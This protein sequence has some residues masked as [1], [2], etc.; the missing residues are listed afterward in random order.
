MIKINSSG[1]AGPRIEGWPDSSAIAVLSWR[2][3]DGR[4]YRQELG[5]EQEAIALLR[6][7]E[8]DDQL[9]LISAQ[10]RRAGIGPSG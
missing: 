1:D 5:S 6:K 3:A 7:I 2:A 10:L 4:S 8:D 9:T